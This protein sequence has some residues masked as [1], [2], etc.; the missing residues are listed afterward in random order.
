LVRFGQFCYCAK[1]HAG[2]AF[3]APIRVVNE[4]MYSFSLQ[5]KRM[6]PIH[7][8]GPNSNILVRFG[9]FCYCAKNHAGVAFNAP[10]QAINKTM[11]V[12]A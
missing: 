1:N 2:V 7:F 5:M 3:N 10:I 11:I 12:S 9:Q 4:T 6:H 8:L